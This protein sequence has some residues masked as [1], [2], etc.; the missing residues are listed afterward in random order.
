MKRACNAQAGR[1]F[2][3]WKD[4]V[5]A[6]RRKLTAVCERVVRASTRLL[7]AGWRTWITNA[8]AGVHGSEM[9]RMT[10]ELA[11]LRQESKESRSMIKVRT[12]RAGQGK[13]L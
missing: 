2:T 5:V 3:T 10:A 6:I 7:A 8:L 11:A 9:D 1:A 13:V 12:S 4:I